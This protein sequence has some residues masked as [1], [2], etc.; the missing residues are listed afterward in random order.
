MTLLALPRELRDQILTHL[1][2]PPYIYTSSAKPDTT[3]LHRGKTDAATYI[4]TRIYLPVRICPAALGVCRQLRVEGLEQCARVVHMNT[5]ASNGAGGWDGDIGLKG[6]GKSSIL[7]SRLG[8]ENDD[9]AERHIDK[10]T[11]RITLE[12][13]RPQRGKFGYA[14]PVRDTLSP[15]FTALLPLLQNTKILRI[16]V[17]P[18]FEW[19][20]GAR[21][22][23][24][25]GRKGVDPIA[26][27]A[28]D[29]VS[30]AL[31][32]V[33]AQLPRVE[34]VEVDV[35]AHVGDFS[36]WDLPDEK[37]V[38]VQ[39]WL[40]SPISPQGE[41]RLQRVTRRLSGVWEGGIVEAFYVQEETKLGEGWRLKRHGDMR[42]DMVL[43][44]VDPGEL[45]GYGVVDEEFER[46][47]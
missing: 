10:K 4:D 14:I 32:A 12:A 6:G 7:A 1:L 22:G 5:K 27:A 30:Y 15:R 40:D 24:T 9:A 33:L 13:K 2:L 38:P 20:S 26:P 34:D 35:L 11:P 21:P 19:W 43:D 23:A 16:V 18:G 39:Y 47:Y 42:T 45:D 29:A 28:L 36:R 37:W 31:G 8:T 41:N 46:V 25:S 44:L 17:W 3:N